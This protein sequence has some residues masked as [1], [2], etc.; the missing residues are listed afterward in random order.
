MTDSEDSLSNSEDSVSCLLGILKPLSDDPLSY[1]RFVFPSKVGGRPAWLEPKNLPTNLLCG[2]CAHKLE[3]LLQ[4]YAPLEEDEV[5]HEEAFHRTL[6]VFYCIN[7]LCS[8]ESNFCKVFRS[9]L[10]AK[11]PFYSSDYT[12][13]M[14]RGKQQNFREAETQICTVCCLPA[15]L[16][17]G[18][19]KRRVYCS[20]LCQ[21]WDWKLGH[22]RYCS[23]NIDQQRQETTNISC[24]PSFLLETLEEPIQVESISNNFH[25]Q[26]TPHEDEDLESEPVCEERDAVFEHFQLRTMR[27]PKQVLR[28]APRDSSIQPL[29]Y[30]KEKRITNSEDIPPCS[31]CHGPRVF[32]FQV[33]PQLLYYLQAS[34]QSKSQIRYQEKSIDFGT[35]VVYTCQKSCSLRVVGE[36]TTSFYSEEFAVVQDAF[37]L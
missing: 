35:I 25:I 7:P 29:W 9:Q 19:C 3:Y 28:Y 6:F 33:M 11:N 8:H 13:N 22:K 34:E 26:E 37:S 27:E 5:G 30:R 21:Q 4:I 31:V 14:E 32:E 15:S 1:S 18:N 20:K 36:E 17:C 24:F 12:K 2:S 10:A 16:V 23:S